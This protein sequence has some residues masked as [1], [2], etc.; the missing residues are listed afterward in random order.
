MPVVVTL[1][2][3]GVSVK[4]LPDAQYEYFNVS[5]IVSTLPDVD[6][7]PLFEA[8]GETNPRP[9][10][11]CTVAVQAHPPPETDWHVTDE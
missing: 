4:L 2:L 6:N 5:S 3:C 7:E 1:V 11:C 10:V 9:P 8:S